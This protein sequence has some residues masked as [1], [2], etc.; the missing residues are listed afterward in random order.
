MI[1]KNF[2]N[3]LYLVMV[4]FLGVFPTSFWDSACTFRQRNGHNLLKFEIWL[5]IRGSTLSVLLTF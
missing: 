1:G 4:G 3:M 5:V 2:Q